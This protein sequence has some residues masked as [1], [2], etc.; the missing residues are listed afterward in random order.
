MY[1]HLLIRPV[2]EHVYI[3][4]FLRLQTFLQGDIL[5]CLPVH[6]SEFLSGK[7]LDVQLLSFRTCAS[8]PLVDIANLLPKMLVLTFPSTSSVAKF[9]C[10]LTH[11]WY[12]TF[13]YLSP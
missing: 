5:G 13:Q 7:H 3:L 11:S 10:N 9:P 12:Q 6:V 2:Y 8:S 4:L 1:H